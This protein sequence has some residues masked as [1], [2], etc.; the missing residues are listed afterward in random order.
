[1]LCGFIIG[2]VK[3][4]FDTVEP[5]IRAFIPKIT[6]WSTCD[7][8]CAGLKIA[9]KQPERVF[10]FL[11]PFTASEREFDVR[12]ALAMLDFH[13]VNEKYIEKIFEILDGITHEGYYV[14]MASAWCLSTCLIK[15]PDKALEYLSCCKLDDFTFNKALQKSI[16]S[17]RVKPEMKQVLKQMKRKRVN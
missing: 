4:D 9:K 16:E 15:F 11:L 10:E 8:V 17:Y 13:F 7:S 5:Y 6:N 3:S 14:R 2:F 1:M 12:F